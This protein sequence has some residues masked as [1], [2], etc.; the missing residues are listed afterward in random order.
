MAYAH[1]DKNDFLCPVIDSRKGE[2]YLAIYDQ[3]EGCFRA[4]IS[5]NLSKF[6]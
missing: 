4:S 6:F 1:K 5:C 2:V 3:N